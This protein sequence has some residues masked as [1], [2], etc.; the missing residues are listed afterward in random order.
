VTDPGLPEVGRVV[1]VTE[2]HPKDALDAE[3]AV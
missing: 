2:R 1:V 3:T